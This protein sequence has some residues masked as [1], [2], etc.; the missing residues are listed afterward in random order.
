MPF[1]LR[2]YGPTDEDRW[3][4]W[5]RKIWGMAITAGAITASVKYYIDTQIPPHQQAALI[6]KIE[7]WL[8]AVP[9]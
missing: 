6:A 4:M 7:S 9:K 1:K 8:A 2:N 3:A 5:R